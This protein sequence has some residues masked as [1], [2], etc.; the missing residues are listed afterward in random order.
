MKK[1]VKHKFQYLLFFLLSMPAFIFASAQDIRVNIDFTKASLGSVLNE[2]GRQ[3]SL[4]IVYNTG[5][6]NPTQ[7]VSIKAS[8]ENITTVM[9]RL[10][11]G[12]G[13]SYSIMNKHLILST[14][15]KNH[16]IQQEKVTV[17]GN[18]SDAKGEPL[19]GVSILVKGTS[20]GTITDMNGHFSLPVAKGDVIEISYIGYAPQAITVTDSKP[21]K[22]VMKEDA[23]V[24]DEVVVTALGIKRAQ[25]ALSYN[26]QQVG[27]DAINT[28]KDANFINS[29]QG[30]VAG[31]T[32][33]NSA[34]GVGSASR[35]VMRG[36]KSITKD[37]NALYVI[38][39]IPMFNVSFGKS[40]GSFATQSGSD[41]VADLNPDDIE[42]INMLTGPSAAALYGNAAANGVVLINTK[43][44]SAEK[45]TLT[46]SN[47]TMFS[48]AYMMPEMQ[49]RYGNNP[50]EF[51]SWG[52]KTK[53]SY[54]PSRFF[55]TGVN[56]INAISFSTGTKKNQTYA[57]ASTTNA[58]GILPNNSY[59]RYNFS[60]RNTA[61]FLKDRLTLDVGA[62]YIIQNDKN[63]TA[64]GQYFNPL[65]ALYL[66][67]RNDNFEEIRMFERYSESRGVNVQ[68][69]P[70]GHQGLS[71][72]NPYWI[73]KRM[74]R[75]TEKKRYMINA[76]LTY[77]LTDWL[78]VAG[79]VK[80]DNSDIRMTQERY[81]STLTTFAGA[82]GFY[83][84][85]N[86]TDRNTYADMMVN[87]DKRIGDFSLNA[88]IGVRMEYYNL[89][90][91]GYSSD[92][93]TPV[94]LDNRT[95]DFFPSVNISYNLSAKHLVRAAY[96]RSVNRP[97]FREVVPYVY[98]N[99]ERDANIVGNTE[100]KNAYADNL[101]VRYEFYPASG[102]MITVGA[103]YKR[104]KDPIEETYNEA[105]SG[106]QY[107]YHNAK[108]AETF[109]IEL[110]MKK[111]LDFIGLRGLSLVCNAAYI[112]SRVRFEE[113]APERDRPLAGQS[114]YLVNA[115]LFYQHDDKGISASLLYNRIGKRIESV[116]VPMQDQNEDIPDI[117][118]MPRNSLD[119]T[120]SKKIGKAVEIKAGIQDMLNSKIEYKQFVKLTDKNGGKR[121]RE[122]LVRSYR[123][124]VDINVGVS[125]KF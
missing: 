30:K 113:G 109:G 61:T 62:S 80:V 26:V 90:M 110:D 58:T 20:N 3:T 92:G 88:N 6:V 119:L 57:S 63:I 51:A 1:S 111:S 11:R 48:D 108:N 50:G 85:Q 64:Q 95:S 35:V 38:D 9:N 47:N 97:E 112:H 106:L 99:F 44:G 25:K 68:F 31:V 16:S 115:G 103:F 12:T 2:I 83:S 82:N 96:G 79:R 29:L 45:T 121:E 71:L 10:L 36:T 5:D 102:E 54:D 24:L 70:Y 118:E 77:K 37:N 76:S 28:V 123:P 65:P 19:I 66:F 39:G 40:E 69:W 42:S 74:N 105:G 43:K 120:F 75:K 87:I 84:D 91:D 56:V 7:P 60:I 53:Q 81:A 55:N 49:N 8:N 14:T 15:D 73:M 104:F 4:S 72:Q 32:I 94:H 86:R 78:N 18:I 93:T 98:F 116:G 125:L 27:G 41:G 34:G 17:T 100:L 46:V 107:T 89:K 117:Y 59:S 22:I 33:N 21:L 122:Q 67:P 101:E 114:P 23:E 13:L 124:G 52:N